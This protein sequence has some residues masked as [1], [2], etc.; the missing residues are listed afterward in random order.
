MSSSLFK[1]TQITTSHYN[2]EISS[3]ETLNEKPYVCLGN[4]LK[5]ES[6]SCSIVSDSLQPHGL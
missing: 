5:S 4:I 3:N 1:L 2:K 6:V